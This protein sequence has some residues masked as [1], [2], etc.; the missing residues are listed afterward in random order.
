MI[1]PCDHI[2]SAK[3]L[4]RVAPYDNV[5]FESLELMRRLMRAHLSLAQAQE[6]IKI[7]FE[8]KMEKEGWHTA[9]VF[10]AI[11]YENKG[12]ISIYDLE[13]LL[14]NHVRGGSRSLVSD[15]ELLISFYDK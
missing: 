1:V 9:E 6:Y 10:R 14:I 4:A 15:L 5:G 2:S 13:K 12:W 8:K 11:D 3:L 7:R